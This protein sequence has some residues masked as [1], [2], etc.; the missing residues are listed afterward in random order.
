MC[1]GAPY[2]FTVLLVNQWLEGNQYL[3]RISADLFG[4]GT[5][6]FSEYERGTT[7]PARVKPYAAASTRSLRAE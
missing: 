7:K 1:K 6:A 2:F 5:N 4:G 3:G